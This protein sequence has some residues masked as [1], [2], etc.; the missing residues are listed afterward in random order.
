MIAAPNAP[1]IRASGVARTRELRAA[2]A[3]DDDLRGPRYRHLLH[4][5]VEDAG[6]EPSLAGRAR[7][8]LLVAPPQSVITGAAGLALL[9]VALP[10]RWQHHIQ[11]VV[12]V[13]VPA[14]ALARPQ[15]RGVRVTRTS[16]T[17]KA[18]R[19]VAGV[20]VAH[21][22]ECWLQLAPWATWQEL[23]MV[24]DGLLRRRNPLVS[25]RDLDRH[26]EGAAGR[27]GVRCAKVARAFIRPR[28]DSIAETWARP[29]IPA[30]PAHVSR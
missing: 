26:L 19:V 3:S 17:P 8:A 13:Q 23:V 14:A 29:R 27:R 16:R 18:W 10:R 12:D 1:S 30:S 22:V 25:L 21:P 28:T 5:V 2:G 20:R 4:G 11:T 15:R 24:G 9:G 6:V 7:A